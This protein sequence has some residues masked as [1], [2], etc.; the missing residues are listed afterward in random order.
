MMRIACVLITHLRAK[1][2]MRRRPDVADR[3]FIIVVRG[4]KKPVVV[5]H[6]PAAS[7]ITVGMT[8][9]QAL[10]QQADT[11]I[12]EADEPT[13]RSVFR[14]TLT[15]LQQVS[16]Q[17]ED[18]ELG[19]AYVRVSGLDEMYDGEDALTAALHAAIPSYLQ[20]RIGIGEGKFPAFVCRHRRRST[21]CD[22][23]AAGRSGFPVS[24][25]H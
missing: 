8:P 9:E 1:I 19:T 14:Q 2:E 13:Y 25:L 11:V 6:S 23:R 4:Q 5:D 12:L 24:T 15:A 3:P 21:Q 10:S 20:V 17:V 22:N 7:H 16:D 18:A